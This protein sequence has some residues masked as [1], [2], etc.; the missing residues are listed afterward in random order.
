MTVLTDVAAALWTQVLS[1]TTAQQAV[2]VITAVTTGIHQAATGAAPSVLASIAQA[3]PDALKLIEQVAEQ[4]GDLV[5]GPL[6]GFA[7]KEAVALL[8]MS[9][10][11]TPE[12]EQRW[13]DRQSSSEGSS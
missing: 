7:A 1:K 10:A 2:G 13:F 5:G 12:D 6:G 9:H 3:H 11:M 8:A 4:A